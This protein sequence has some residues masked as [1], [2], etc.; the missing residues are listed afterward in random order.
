MPG[1][2][3][4]L[5]RGENAVAT[6]IGGNQVI[7]EGEPMSLSKA[8][9]TALHKLGYKTSAAS[10]SDYWM[11]GDKTLDEIRTSK[12]SSGVWRFIRAVDLAPTGVNCS[13]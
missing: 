8:A 6:V 4:T 12:G 11:Y 13:R 2:Q 10:G 3:L 7:Y 5:S 9:L 1:T